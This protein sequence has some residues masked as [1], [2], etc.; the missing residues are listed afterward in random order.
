[1]Q[2]TAALAARSIAL[3]AGTHVR[4]GELSLRRIGVMTHFGS[5]PPA[6]HRDA[7]TCAT[8][9]VEAHSAA[10]DGPATTGNNRR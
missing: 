2:E 1:M 10:S 3:S 6:F 9:R 8:L 5:D 4:S 7:A